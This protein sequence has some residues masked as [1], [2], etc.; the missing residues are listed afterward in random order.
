MTSFGM[1]VLRPSEL[2]PYSLYHPQ[3]LVEP[4]Q[5]RFLHIRQSAYS[6]WLWISLIGLLAVGSLSI[7][8]A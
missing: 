8:L 1:Y 4:L 5:S 3:L 7:A 2:P 6:A